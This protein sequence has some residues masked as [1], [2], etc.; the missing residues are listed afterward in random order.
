MSAAVILPAIAKVAQP[1]SIFAVEWE[2]SSA[3]DT[4]THMHAQGQL[5][6]SLSGLISIVTPQ[7]WWVVPA[8]HAIW[9]PP[10][11]PHGVRSHGP[12]R[13]WSVYVATQNCAELPPAPQTL[14]VSSLLR[15]LVHRATTWNRTPASA[16]EYR[17]ARVIID[18]I[19]CLREEPLGLSRPRDERLCQIVDAMLADLTD[20]RSVGDWAE[21][22][23]ITPRTLARH[24][25]EQTGLGM[26]AW[27]Q[28][29][30]VLRAIEM[31]AIGK[32]VTTIAM[33]L[34][35]DNVSAFIAMFR[36]VTGVTPGEYGRSA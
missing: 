26:V 25:S 19:A 4:A 35:Y 28:R 23:G 15:E 21:W 22:A 10:H 29:A 20:N 1:E 12:F 17:L 6:G 14:R 33:D 36:R 31:L 3:R 11:L 27:R 16:A 5:I 9:L 2:E 30:R 7:A 32:T 18:E 8:T 34:G 24:F 13:G